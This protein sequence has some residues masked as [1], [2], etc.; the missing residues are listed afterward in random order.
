MH[1]GLSIRQYIGIYM[2]ELIL[3]IIIWY[4]VSAPLA[5]SYGW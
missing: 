5:V 1:Y 2:R 3:G 4:V